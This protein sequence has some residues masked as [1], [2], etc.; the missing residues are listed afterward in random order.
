[1]IIVLTFKIL[2]P[3]Q[4]HRVLIDIISTS[5]NATPGLGRYAPFKREVVLKKVHPLQSM[6]LQYN[7]MLLF[8]RFKVIAIATSALDTFRNEANKMV[9][10]LVDMERAFVPPQ[11][12]IRLL[13]RRLVPSTIMFVFVTLSLYITLDYFLLWVSQ[14]LLF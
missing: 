7:N 2:V 14:S 10:A 3:K 6:C 9:I 12:F 13:Q 8:S 11:H 1:M 5:A 4:V